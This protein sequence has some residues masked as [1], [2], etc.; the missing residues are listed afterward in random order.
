MKHWHST[1]ADGMDTPEPQ[2]VFTG[3]F[4]TRQE[5]VMA[6]SP[7]IAHRKPCE[8]AGC[9][10][11]ARKVARGVMDADLMLLMPSRALAVWECSAPHVDIC[12]QTY[13]LVVFPSIMEIHA[14]GG[15][16]LPPL[17]PASWGL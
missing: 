14:R 4:P 2:S 8:D 7:L 1:A 11:L 5:A 12:E 16:P 10:D 9:R 3:P 13:L 17:P 15:I 6:L